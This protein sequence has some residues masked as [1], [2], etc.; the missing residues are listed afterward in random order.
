M[1]IMSGTSSSMLPLMA[2]QHC[3]SLMD[4]Y[5]SSQEFSREPL[6]LNS[7]LSSTIEPSN[8]EEA[9]KIPQ[10]NSKRRS[11]GDLVE[12]YKKLL[13]KRDTSQEETSASTKEFLNEELIT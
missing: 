11:I 1:P 4:S 6:L 12:R 8:S 2:K 9:E 5:N 3:I 7:K 10:K 13:Q